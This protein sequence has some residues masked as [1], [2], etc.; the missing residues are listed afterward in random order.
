MHDGQ[1]HQQPGRLLPCVWQP[2][3][4]V[5]PTQR[6]TTSVLLCTGACND[7]KGQQHPQHM[8]NLPTL[9]NAHISS[10]AAHAIHSIYC[11]VCRF[12]TT[13]SSC[14]VWSQYQSPAKVTTALCLAKQKQHF[15]VDCY[16]EPVAAVTRYDNKEVQS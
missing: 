7:A 4:P 2:A 6:S 9:Q 12:S 5:P 15:P 3:A 10:H 13:T 16:D 14:T 8:P 1:S 11:C